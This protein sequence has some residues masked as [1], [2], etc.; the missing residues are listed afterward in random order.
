MPQNMWS[1][2]HVV[3]IDIT[4]S[5][6]DLGASSKVYLPTYLHTYVPTH[7]LTY[8]I[9]SISERRQRRTLS[10]TPVH[11]HPMHIK[12]VPYL[13]HLCTCTLCTCTLCTSKVYPVFHATAV[14]ARKCISTG[15]RTI[16]TAARTLAVLVLLSSERPA[17]ESMRGH[18]P[19]LSSPLSDQRSSPCGERAFL[20]RQHSHAP[21]GFHSTCDRTSCLLAARHPE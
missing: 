8:D 11:M 4:E 5:K 20:R 3:D 6:I 19:L 17:F 1:L 21:D 15:T 14:I 9:T 18:S 16:V 7:L 12:G 10:S 13:P 2:S